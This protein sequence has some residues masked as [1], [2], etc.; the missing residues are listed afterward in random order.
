MSRITSTLGAAALM[1]AAGTVPLAGQALGL[2]S[3]DGAVDWN[4][5]YTAAET[6]Q[7]LREFADLYPE[8]TEVYSIG[9]S[10][11]GQ[12]LMVIE[13]T[14]EATGPAEEKPALYVDGGIHAAE[15]TGSAV[16]TY[17]IGH[18]L[19]GYGNDPRVTELL[20]TRVFYVRPKFNPDGSDLVLLEDQFL[21]STPHPIDEDEDG[22][23]DDDPPQ[24]LNGDGWIT[25]MRVPSA[26]GVWDDF[27]RAC[28]LPR[29]SSRPKSMTPSRWKSIRLIC[30]SMSIVPVARAVST[31][32]GPNR[33]CGLPIIPPALSCNARTTVPSTKTKP[34]P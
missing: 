18:L 13:I 11:Y 15:L 4:R 27:G 29:Y 19:N 7:M 23:A 21:R 17:F 26:D 16:A 24:D 22:V 33:R 34:R 1:L 8:L 28:I 30:A 32:T 3:P 10:F 14:N 31:S 12:P 20:D 5:F 9:E 6:N 2:V 25:Q